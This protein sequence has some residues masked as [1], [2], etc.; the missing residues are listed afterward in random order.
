MPLFTI[1]TAYRLPVYR[2]QIYEADTLEQAC[3]RAMD[4]DDWEHERRDY[5]SAGETFVSGAWIGHTAY[6]GRGELV[7]S[8][9]AEVIQ[10]KVGHFE[11]LL[12]LL[13]V[14]AQDRPLDAA[15]REFWAPRAKAAIAKGEAILG[16]I[17]DPEDPSADAVSYVVGR[18]INRF[19]EMDYLCAW[20]A[21]WGTTASA[22]VNAFRF[23]TLA[24][25]EF[26]CARA[27]ALVPTFLDGRPIEYRAVP[28]PSRPRE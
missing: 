13:K 9:F 23:P 20:D 26:A 25:A 19:G 15:E 28:A 12:G 22:L 21:K 10:R 8:R 4:D 3:R 17:D 7:P 5:E 6:A 11:V 2:H 27:R 16:G 24:E 14:F 1:E 18:V